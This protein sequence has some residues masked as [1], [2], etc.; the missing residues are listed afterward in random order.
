MDSLKFIAP[1]SETFID[2]T[3]AYARVENYLCS[4]RIK[5]KLLLSQ[6]VAQILGSVAQR[7]AEET[8]ESPSVLAMQEAENVVEEWF[9]EVLSAAGV[10]PD[11]LG[12]KGR[13]ALFMSDLPTRWQ[14]EFLHPG[15]WPEE[16]LQA[17]KSTYL[18]TGPDFQKARMTARDIDLGPVSAVADETWRVIDRWPLVGATLV[19]AIYLGTV[20]LVVY[21]LH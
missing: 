17:I 4:L 15:P 14:N 16:F 20:G 10:S 5:N 2:W 21:L 12:V 11:N 13:L 19:W 3:E 1:R 6:L 18:K 8:G 9:R 7:L